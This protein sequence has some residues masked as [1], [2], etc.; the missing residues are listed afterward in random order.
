MTVTNKIPYLSLRWSDDGRS[1][2]NIV[3]SNPY[4][5]PI[6]PKYTPNDDNRFIY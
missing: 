2:P 4:N 6:F 3:Y 1:N 5:S